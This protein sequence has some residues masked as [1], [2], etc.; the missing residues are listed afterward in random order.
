MGM[1]IA[2]RECGIDGG[3]C[4]GVRDEGVWGEGV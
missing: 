2:M 4:E 1:S 3:E